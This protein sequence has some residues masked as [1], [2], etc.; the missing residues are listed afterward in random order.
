MSIGYL[1]LTPGE[2]ECLYEF[3]KQHPTDVLRVYTAKLISFEQKTYSKK[4][5]DMQGHETDIADS[6][7][8]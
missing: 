2:L 5:T 3:H 6:T 4:V 1:D 7:F 8:E